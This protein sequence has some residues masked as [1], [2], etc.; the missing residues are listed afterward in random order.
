[1]LTHGFYYFLALS[2]LAILGL[3]IAGIYLKVKRILAMSVGRTNDH[4]SKHYVSESDHVL[5]TGGDILVD[6]AAAWSKR[7]GEP[8]SG[9]RPWA[10]NA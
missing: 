6:N 7:A 1:M 5:R 2:E 4:N 10:P 8:R 3:I 9:D